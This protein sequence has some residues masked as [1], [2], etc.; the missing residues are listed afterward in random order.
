MSTKKYRYQIFFRTKSISKR[1]EYTLANFS[2]MSFN[3][4]QYLSIVRVFRRPILRNDVGSRWLER[5]CS[6]TSRP[7]KS[8]WMYSRQSARQQRR[9][10]WRDGDVIFRRLYLKIFRDLLYSLSSRA[11]DGGQLFILS[12][13]VICGPLH[14]SSSLSLRRKRDRR[15]RQR[16]A[17][18][19]RPISVDGPKA[20]PG[21]SLRD[22]EVKA[23]PSLFSDTEAPFSPSHSYPESVVIRNAEI[24]DL[25]LRAGLLKLR[26]E[27]PISVTFLF[28]TAT[29]LIDRSTE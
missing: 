24:S 18:H 27:L 15:R 13:R 22:R 7:R 8:I 1:F 17:V 3:N 20:L 11:V 23:T 26:G 2:W 12:R 21:Y 5:I 29:T 19:I 28:F 6:L 16:G 10:R 9:R 25:S 14:L 4:I